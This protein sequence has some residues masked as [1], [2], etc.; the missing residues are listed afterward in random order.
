MTDD[1]IYESYLRY[2]DSTLELADVVERNFTGQGQKKGGRKYRVKVGEY[3]KGE[4]PKDMSKLL[5][6]ADLSKVDQGEKTLYTVGNYRALNDAQKRAN[7]L[8]ND[9]FE[10]VDVIKKNNKGEYES[11]NIIT[12]SPPANVGNETTESTEN[13][14]E[15]DNQVVFRV[16][17]GAFKQRPEENSDF[18]KIPSLFVVE[19]G[20][21]YRY[22][23]GSFNTFNDAANHKVKMVVEGY[24][25]AFVVAYK[26]GKRVSLRSV[27]INPISSD[28]IIGK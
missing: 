2:K 3:T 20:G 22:M 18:N 12:Q 4:T 10:D 1:M 26:N 6:L 24:K 28:P 11:L 9:G 16:Q 15:Q 7:K 25:G 21:Y 19:S 8:S 17:L 23:S 13:T 14:E 27:G 5:S